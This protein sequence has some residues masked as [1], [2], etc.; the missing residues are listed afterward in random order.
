MD[1][2]Y[3]KLSILHELLISLG[4]HSN[5]VL[6][7]KEI[8]G[9]DLMIV[10]SA[11]KIKIVGE[12]I[13]ILNLKQKTFFANQFF[14]DNID[15]FEGKIDDLIDKNKSV[16]YRIKN[17][18]TLH[19]VI[20]KITNKHTHK[21]YIGKTKNAFFGRWYS[22]FKNRMQTKFGKEIEMYSIV[23]WTFEVLEI[24]YEQDINERERYWIN[25]FNSVENGYN[26]F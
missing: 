24:V 15:I 11:D 10:F 3:Y 18:N 12:A 2:V 9:L 21:C 14:I 23:D 7:I 26:T 17:K 1:K 25:E 6:C 20:Y 13:C 8:D 4:S 19:N 22:H 5:N 16:S